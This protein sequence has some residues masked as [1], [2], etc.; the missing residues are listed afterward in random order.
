MDLALVETASRDPPGWLAKLQPKPVFGTL[1]CRTGRQHRGKARAWWA[2]S[3]YPCPRCSAGSS[4]C[5]A[6]VLSLIRK[7]VK[8]FLSKLGKGLDAPDTGAHQIQV[9]LNQMII[10]LLYVQYLMFLFFLLEYFCY[11]QCPSFFPP[12]HLPFRKLT[13]WQLPSGTRNLYL[14]MHYN[15]YNNISTRVQKV[16]KVEYGFRKQQTHF[17][18]FHCCFRKETIKDSQSRRG[19]ER[20]FL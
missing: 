1:L 18:F 14:S 3:A 12:S 2:V 20:Y 9:V 15:N 8:T 13:F 6:S 16:R 5:T 19:T 17:S 7:A 11:Q 10:Q 4:T